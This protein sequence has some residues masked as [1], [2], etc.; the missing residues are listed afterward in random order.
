MD[1]FARSPFALPQA[2]TDRDFQQP[3]LA[4]TNYFCP[5]MP[6]LQNLRR[7]Y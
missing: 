5:D 2:E 6:M 7:S 3:A 1:R 4:S